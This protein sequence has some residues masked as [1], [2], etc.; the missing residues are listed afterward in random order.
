MSPCS[1]DGAFTALARRVVCYHPIDANPDTVRRILHERQPVNIAM[2]LGFDAAGMEARFGFGG[3]EGSGYTRVA[4]ASGQL[5]PNIAVYCPTP[6]GGP[7]GPVVHVVNSI[8]FAFDSARQPDYQHF[9]VCAD[10]SLNPAKRAELVARLTTVYRLVFTCAR[11]LGLSRVCISFIGGGAFCGLYPGGARAYF[12]EAYLP[13][14]EAA[15]DEALAV[16]Q[17]QQ[18]QQAGPGVGPSRLTTIGLIGA[19]YM[20]AALEQRLELAVKTRGLAYKKE[21]RVPDCLLLHQGPEA[22]QTLWQNAWDC[23]SIAGN[24]NAGD[25]SLDGYFGRSTAISVLTFPSTN[26]AGISLRAVP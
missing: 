16:Q 7:A 4:V 11:D 19:Q 12:N 24:G 15:L 20:D 18:Q 22:S 6:V 21:G 3:A 8:A 9:F 5:P 14:L 25:N 10:G 26:P 23:H 2:N 17:Q 1:G 13:A